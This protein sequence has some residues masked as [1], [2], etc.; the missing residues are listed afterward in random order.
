MRASLKWIRKRVP[1]Q[2]PFWLPEDSPQGALFVLGAVSDGL[3]FRIQRLGFR[4]QHFCSPITQKS[5]KGGQ[6]GVPKVSNVIEMRT[7]KRGK[8]VETQS[9]GHRGHTDQLLVD[10]DTQGTGGWFFAFSL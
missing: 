3:G 5:I 1:F 2:I 7:P 4:I 8:D 10:N 6:K 9:K